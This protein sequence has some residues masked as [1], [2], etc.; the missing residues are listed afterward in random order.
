MNFVKETEGD[1]L[2]NPIWEK[3]GGEYLEM[4]NTYL[5]RNVVKLRQE[6]GI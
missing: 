3:Y 4:A 1:T 6:L 5:E 2:Y